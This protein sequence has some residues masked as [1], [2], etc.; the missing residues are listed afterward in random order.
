MGACPKAG[1]GACPHPGL[2]R[3]A[4]CRYHGYLWN[5]CC[6]NRVWQH[7][8]LPLVDALLLPGTSEGGSGGGGGGGSTPVHVGELRARLLRLMCADAS[9]SA[10]DLM[11]IV[12]ATNG[13]G[14]GGGLDYWVEAVVPAEPSELQQWVWLPQDL[15]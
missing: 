6:A 3:P 8:M 2:C 9:T 4:G 15:L 10:Q 7:T 5:W 14:G 13:G 1:W 12:L 11:D